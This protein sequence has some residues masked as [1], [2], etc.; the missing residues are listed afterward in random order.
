MECTAVVYRNY[1]TTEVN[2]LQWG[3]PIERVII[4]YGARVDYIWHLLLF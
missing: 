1:T 3:V 2:V 4:Y